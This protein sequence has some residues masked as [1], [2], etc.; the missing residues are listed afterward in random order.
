MIDSFFIFVRSLYLLFDGCFWKNWL[1]VDTDI[2]ID[3]D[4][5]SWIACHL[6]ADAVSLELQDMCSHREWELS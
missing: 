4:I 1:D 5:D 2:D 3:I 6:T